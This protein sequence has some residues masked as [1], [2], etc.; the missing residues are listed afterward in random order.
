MIVFFMENRIFNIRSLFFLCIL[1][2]L[3][4]GCIG[5]DM[6]ACAEYSVSVKIVDSHGNDLNESDRV[7]SV[8]LYLFDEQGFVRVVPRNS[9]KAFL[10]GEEKDKELTL[11]G[12]GNLNPDSVFVPAILPGT[13]IEDA[14]LSVLLLSGGNARAVNDLFYSRLHISPLRTRGVE[15]RS[16]TLVLSSV[17]SA[18]SV[19]TTGLRQWLGANSDS[20][21]VVIEN[22]GKSL[23]FRGELTSETTGYEPTVNRN[24]NGD[25][26]T[27][28][29]RILPTGFLR[30]LTLNIYNG[31]VKIF[32]VSS[33][34][35]GNPI[36]AQAG[37]ILRL[38]IHFEYA[39]VKTIVTV[40]PW[41]ETDQN[42]QL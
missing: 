19:Q 28:L 21:R 12:W 37:R 13:S 16:D 39:S 18:M 4:A 40:T 5:E 30:T 7:T 29:F 26:N 9:S 32:S 2:L 10:L 22:A 27:G 1:S 23:N 8:D 35:E 6:S 15:Q 24:V 14:Q 17:S 3:C 20:C 41:E 36:V 34:V 31:D 11:V 33:D 25:L 42:T 38:Y